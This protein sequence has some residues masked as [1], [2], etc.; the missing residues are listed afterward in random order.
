[1]KKIT[2]LLSILLASFLFLIA[3]YLI[4]T[5]NLVSLPFAQTKRVSPNVLY[6]TSP[7][8]SFEGK[9]IKVEGNNIWLTK[10]FTLQQPPPPTPTPDQ[11]EITYKVIVSKDTSI[12]QEYSE[13]PYLATSITPKPRPT[14]TVNDIKVGQYLVVNSKSDLRT[15]TSPYFEA[16][17]INI[18]AQ[19]NSVSGKIT[20]IENNVI[21]LEATPPRYEPIEAEAVTDNNLQKVTY[22]VT[23]TPETEISAYLSQEAP[24]PNIEPPSPQ[25]KTF[26][27]KDLKKEM[28]VTVFADVDVT[29]TQQL[30]ALR[31]EP[32]M[33]S[34]SAISP[35]PANIQELPLPSESE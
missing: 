12:N 7:I 10:R 34:L 21:Y 1:M 16:S 19:I 3:G 8:N 11:K 18:P 15:L 4:G 26:S 17:Y 29:T 25:I 31:I 14:L 13:V 28:Q 20:Q 27:L 32:D 23:V 9:V 35:T 5:K 6:L 22:A 24:Y 2:S 30:T 33:I